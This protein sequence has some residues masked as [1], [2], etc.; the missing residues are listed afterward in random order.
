MTSGT[1]IHVLLMRLTTTAGHSEDRPL[2][3]FTTKRAA[4]QQL[5]DQKRWTPIGT[6]EDGVKTA[7][8]WIAPITLYP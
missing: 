7:D 2:A 6:I 3:A 4:Q 8:Y 5:R 1:R